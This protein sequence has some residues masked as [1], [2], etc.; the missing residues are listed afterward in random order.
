VSCCKVLAWHLPVVVESRRICQFWYSILYSEWWQIAEYFLV[1]AVGDSLSK[2]QTF[3]SGFIYLW[4]L[5]MWGHAV[6]QSVE[7]PRYKP[8]VWRVRFLLVIDVIILPFDL[9]MS[10]WGVK[11]SGAYGWQHSH[12]RVPIVLKS[13]ERQP[14]GAPR[15]CTGLALLFTL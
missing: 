11:A 15:A 8:E 13:S 9:E 1:S 7:G 4:Y 14:P 3:A 6:A 10:T 12:L 5:L 2:S